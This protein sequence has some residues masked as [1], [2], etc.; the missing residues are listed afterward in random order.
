MFF[1]CLNAKK[2]DFILEIDGEQIV[3]EENPSGIFANIQLKK[4]NHLLHLRKRTYYDTPLW[5]LNI[6]NPLYII[7]QLKF[8]F[9]GKLGYD[10][11]FSAITIAFESSGKQAERI[12]L[13]S[14]KISNVHPD[15]MYYTLNCEQYS[16]VK[17]VVFSKSSM[18]KASIMRYK[19]TR[20]LSVLLYLI[21]SSAIC[22]LNFIKGTINGTE[23]LIFCLVDVWI[24]STPIART[25][26]EKSVAENLWDTK[27][28]RGRL[29]SRKPPE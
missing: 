3:C 29:A 23:A 11:N 7:W 19:L 26:F 24:C 12:E 14:K 15:G 21:I 10:E 6:I 8:I 27:V 22:L 9:A 1:S 20:I 4:G 17:K 25:V 28:H 2:K 18:E 13:V 5:Y 16:G